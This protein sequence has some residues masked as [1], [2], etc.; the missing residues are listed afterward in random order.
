MC[1][2]IVESL[3]SAL[4]RI[5]SAVKW[6]Q[7]KTGSNCAKTHEVLVFQLFMWVSFC[8]SCFDHL[9]ASEYFPFPPWTLM[10]QQSNKGLDFFSSSVLL[11]RC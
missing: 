1:L 4:Q 6:E 8:C 2:G 3:G 9:L 11:I 5:R 7:M 10:E